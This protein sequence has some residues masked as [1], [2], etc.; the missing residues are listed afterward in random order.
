MAV[1]QTQILPAPVLE[2]ALTA[3]TK[4]LQPLISQQIDTS[5]THQA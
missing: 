5:N 1:E 3:F 4:T 2:G